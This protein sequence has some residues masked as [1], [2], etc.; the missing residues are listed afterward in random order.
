MHNQPI[1]ID[2]FLKPE[3][4]REA[5]QSAGYTQDALAQITGIK[6]PSE[7]LNIPMV[8]RQTA[9]PTAFNTFV[10]LFLL[11]GTVPE[12]A[13]KLAVAPANL[14]SLV[15]CG[16]LVRSGAG[17]SSKV[18]IVQ[19]G[20]QFFASD[21]SP[22]DKGAAIASDHVL[23][24][25]PASLVLVNLTVRKQVDSAF[26]LGCGSGVQS[27]IAARHARRVVGG[28]TNARALNLAAFVAKLNGVE[29]IEWRT[30]SFFEPVEGEKFD[31]VVANPPFVI[32]PRSR[33]QFRDGGLGGDAVSEHVVRGAARHLNEGGF[34]SM[35]INWHHA[36]GE[37]WDRRPMEWFADNGCDSWIARSSI[38]DPL[39]Y[40]A[41]WIGQTSGQNASDYE[42]LL[43][44]WLA[45]FREQ[46]IH[47][48]CAG[49]VVLRK[50]STGKNWT[51]SDSMEQG[52]GRGQCSDHILRLFAG[53][54]YLRQFED[55]RQLLEQRVVLHPDAV[56]DQRLNMENGTWAVQSL[57]I[58]LSS[59][60]G[61]SGKGDIG[62]MR[63][64]GNCNGTTTVGSSIA[65]LA[66]DLK[67]PPES[68]I[69]GC[70]EIVKRMVR[71]G[72]LVP[73]E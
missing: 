15:E 14:E 12:E 39:N 61:F 63:F 44:E 24:V 38:A 43:D 26:D 34:A 10:R 54:D 19:Y 4:F 20:D 68:M 1:K 58:G 50:R 65:K 33:F 3:L 40:A 13:A 37:D 47:Q 53:E 5:L 17:V 23:G 60:L 29:N 35:L 73:V 49:A 28:D 11:A 66:S 16:L 62:V 21:F 67:A 2:S 6:H 32:S 46:G 48:I 9:E 51:R 69:P 27:L 36:D 57:M 64:L 45:Y 59:G 52:Q 70:L 72:I 25:G 8:L 7:K 22:L 56:S 31:L 71:S 30:G 41:N 55:D 42:Q 18:K